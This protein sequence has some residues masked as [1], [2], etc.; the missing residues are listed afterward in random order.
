[1]WCEALVED[2]RGD[3]VSEG[4]RG[5]EG[6]VVGCFFGLAGDVAAD[7]GEE[8]GVDGV[9]EVEEVVADEQS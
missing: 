6:G 7:P 9:D 8:E 2:V 1:M 3:D 4:I 5:V